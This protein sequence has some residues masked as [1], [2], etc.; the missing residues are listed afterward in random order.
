VTH[1]ALEYFLVVFGASC[2]VLQLVAT[3]SGLKGVMLFKQATVSYLLAALTIGGAL[4]WFFGWDNRLEAK[5]MQTGLE[6][7]QQFLYFTLAALSAVVLTLIVS[8]LSKGKSLLP[9]Q[10]G[11]DAQG[12]DVLREMSYFETVRY[13]LGMKKG[14]D[15]KGGCGG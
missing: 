6:G 13:S 4:G 15:N 14:K 11:K 3:H 7:T 1:L 8:S 9:P 5:I 10:Q 12:L 2:G